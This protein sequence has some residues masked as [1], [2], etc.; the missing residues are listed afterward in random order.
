M[1]KG[2]NLS[3]SE[4][5]L[6]LLKPE[7]FRDPNYQDEELYAIASRVIKTDSRR[8]IYNQFLRVPLVDALKAAGFRVDELVIGDSWW[9]EIKW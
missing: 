4:M 6:A 8:V 3:K 7:T 9:T 5:L 2:S 1:E